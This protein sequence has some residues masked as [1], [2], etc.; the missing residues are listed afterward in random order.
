MSSL[1]LDFQETETKH[2]YFE[3]SA[4]MS[5]NPELHEKREEMHRRFDDLKLEYILKIKDL[6]KEY[7][8][9]VDE[10]RGKDHNVP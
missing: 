7:Q 4:L 6:T 9:V 2:G 10:Y 5:N 1:F 8:A 3:L